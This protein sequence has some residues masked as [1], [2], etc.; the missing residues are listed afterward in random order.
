[1]PA[2]ED[3][4]RNLRTMHVVSAASAFALLVATLY[5]MQ[6]DYADEWRPIQR[7]AYKLQAQQLDDDIHDLLELNGKEFEAKEQELAQNVEAAKAAVAAHQ[8]KVQDAEKALARVEGPFQKLSREVRFNR[9]ERD[10]A[11]AN[12]DLQVRDG[13]LGKQLRPWQVKFD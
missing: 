9:A 5:M 11:R 12:L 10:F 2:S 6:A 8:D 1:M 7:D 3:V 4:W 13:A